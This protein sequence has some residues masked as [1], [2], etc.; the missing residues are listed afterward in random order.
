MQRAIGQ[1]VDVAFDPVYRDCQTTGCLPEHIFV[2]GNTW[3]PTLLQNP[4]WRLNAE[5]D[6]WA[7]DETI[8]QAEL[9]LEKAALVTVTLATSDTVQ[10]AT[11]RVINQTGHKLPTGYPEGRQMWLNLLAYDEDNNLIYQSGAY[12]P[13][14][15]QLQ[16]DADVKVY[17]AKQGMTTDLAAFLGQPVGESFHFV[18]NR[19]LCP[20]RI[21]I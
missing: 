19:D 13:L 8:A 11:V 17:E 18:L 12:N 10:I 15:G 20:G 7:L 16:R 14:T 6:N 21:D 5:Y 2:G 9:M 4:A 1:A 3:V